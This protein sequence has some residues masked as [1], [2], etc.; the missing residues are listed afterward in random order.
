MRT[1]ERTVVYGLLFL[2]LALGVG[3][4]VDRGPGGAALAVGGASPARAEPAPAK[5]ATCDVYKAMQKLFESDRYAPARQAEHDKAEAELKP[6]ADELQTMRNQ[7]VNADPKDEKAQVAAREF[8]TKSQA[9]RKRESELER[10]Y[11]VFM[12]KQF[13]ECYELGRASAGTIAQKE[14]YTHVV[15]CRGRLETIVAEDP[16][17]LMEQFLGRPVLSF[18]GDQDITDKVLADLKLSIGEVE[19]KTGEGEKKPEGK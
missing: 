6:Q 9:F 17:T 4:W 1:T 19:K 16:G 15:A 12:G 13:V 14:G 11:Q 3:A 2:A 18:P 8:Q 10:A 5:V 7:L